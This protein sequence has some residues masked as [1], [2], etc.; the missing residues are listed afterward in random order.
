[1]PFYPPAD[2][3][4]FT[5]I[6]HPW[7]VGILC[8]EREKLSSNSEFQI[9]ACGVSCLRKWAVSN[10]QYEPLQKRGPRARGAR[11]DSAATVSEIAPAAVLYKFLFYIYNRS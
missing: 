2:V 1:M 8:K 9:P 5:Q 3:K 7:L 4:G 11:C 6:Y 10:R